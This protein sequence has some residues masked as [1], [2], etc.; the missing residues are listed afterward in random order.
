LTAF[1]NSVLLREKTWIGLQMKKYL[2]ALMIMLL[3]VIS[4]ES[5]GSDKPPN[6]NPGTSQDSRFDT[7]RFNESKFN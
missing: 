5:G 7:A 1:F 2:T 6:N 3:A 4:C